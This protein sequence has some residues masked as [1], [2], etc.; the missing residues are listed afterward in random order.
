MI[1]GFF[2]ISFSLVIALESFVGEKE[3]GSIEPLLHAPLDDWQLYL[4]KLL[5]A[6]L[7]PLSSSFLGMA[8]YL[9]GLVLSGVPL[10]ET[11]MMFLIITLTVVQ[12]I[13]MVSGAVVVSS[14]ATSVRAANLLSSFIIIPIAL[15]VQGESILMFWGSH[16]TLWWAVFGLLILAIILIRLGVTHFQREELLGRE[17]DV[18]NIKWILKTYWLKFTGGAGSVVE[19][20][21]KVIPRAL[22]AIHVPLLITLMIAGVG[23]LVG[24]QEINNFYIPLDESNID[25][26]SE[27]MDALMAMIPIGSVA[28]VLMILWQNVRVLL[29]SM[30]LGVF[31]FGVLGVVPLFASTAVVGYL[32]MLLAVHGLSVTSFLAMIVPHSIIEIPG[33]MIAVAGIIRGGAELITPNTAK[34]VGQSLIETVA[35]WMKLFIGVVVPMLLLAAMIE[36][37][38]TPRIASLFIR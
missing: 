19:W 17:I 2:P 31:T 37:W 15:L 38:F 7:A 12:A 18:L 25:N 20:Y 3:R 34:T 14:Q 13:V 6:I 32:Y 23:I 21:G 27:N 26:L 8:V 29:L 30:V 16:D 36:A 33:A 1:V 35:D 10:P 5:A 4:G 9:I 28:P 24:M 11:S 22:R